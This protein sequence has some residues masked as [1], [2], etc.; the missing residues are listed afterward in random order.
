MA[1]DDDKCCVFLWFVILLAAGS[2]IFFPVF[3]LA[4]LPNL[5]KPVECEILSNNIQSI[6]TSRKIKCECLG[7]PPNP[8]IFCDSSIKF[9]E[10]GI[11][12]DGSCCRDNDCAVVCDLRLCWKTITVINTRF[13]VDDSWNYRTDTKDCMNDFDACDS[14]LQRLTCSQTL[15]LTFATGLRT[16]FYRKSDGKFSFNN[17]ISENTR[18]EGSI[19]GFVFASLFF[20]GS[21]AFLGLLCWWYGYDLCLC[22]QRRNL[23]K[24]ERR[25]IEKRREREEQERKEQE[26][27]QIAQSSAPHMNVVLEG[28]PGGIR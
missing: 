21:A 9:N 18:Q 1:N 6:Y 2:L 7:T 25:A 24:G 8:L 26:L 19:A 20:F 27:K 22:Y 17:D 23:E 4:Y 14:T 28:V 12:Y 15:N 5:I 10:T 11:C 3:Y 16:C 13:K